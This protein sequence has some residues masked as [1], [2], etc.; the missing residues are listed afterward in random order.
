MDT[1]KVIG[2]EKLSYH[3]G[4]DG[5]IDFLEVELNPAGASSDRYSPV[6]TWQTTLSRA[7][8]SEKLRP[9][10]AAAGEF[11]DLKPSR[12]GTSG[13][14]VQIQVI[15]TRGSVLLNGFKVRTRSV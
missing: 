3:L 14:A 13:R 2:N 8:I 11:R 5:K 4:R 1:I 9:L 15:G 7:T 12:F 10:A 6:A